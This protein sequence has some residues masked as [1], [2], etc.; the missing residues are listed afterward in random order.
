MM[1]SSD[2]AYVIVTFR[3]NALQV[4]GAQ[5]LLAALKILWNDYALRIML[6]RARNLTF[7]HL[8]VGGQTGVMNDSAAAASVIGGIDDGNTMG[9]TVGADRV[10]RVDGGM[11]ADICT[12]RETASS[13]VH[14]QTSPISAEYQAN[15]RG[16]L[17]N[18]PCP[19]YIHISQATSLDAYV[20]AF[21]AYESYDISFMIVTCLLNNVLFPLLAVMVVSADCLYRAIDQPSAVT[22]TYDY[23]SCNKLEL[24]L[25]AVQ[26]ILD[27][28]YVCTSFTTESSMDSYY[29]PFLYSYQC[30]S[31]FLR[32]YASL[33]GVMF[34]MVGFLLP[35]AKVL[36][37][38]F[39]A[40]CTPGSR[41][42][43]FVLRLVPLPLRP[44][45]PCL[46]P[47]MRLPVFFEKQRFV[48]RLMSLLSVLL[49]F[50]LLFPPLGLLQCAAL[51]C[52]IYYEQLVLGRL[53][54]QARDRGI[55]YVRCIVEH[56]CS[57]V[58]RPIVQ[59]VSAIGLFACAIFS[60]F[61]FDTLGD[62]V[63]W[64]DALWALFITLLVPPLLYE[65][66]VRT[67]DHWGG[68]SAA[69]DGFTLGSSLL[70]LL[71]PEIVA[72]FFPHLS[73]W[74]N[75]NLRRQ[76]DSNPREKSTR[77]TNAADNG[78]GTTAAGTGAVD[79]STQGAKESR[80]QQESQD[81]GDGAVSWRYYRDS[82]LAS[83]FFTLESASLRHSVVSMQ[84]VEVHARGGAGT[85]ARASDSP[86]LP[87]P[88][89]S[90][91]LMSTPR[92][93]ELEMFS[94]PS[95]RLNS[96]SDDKRIKY[97]LS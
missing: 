40:K 93:S 16:N 6:T 45:A 29:P 41:M 60:F 90:A 81:E 86:R 22:S 61:V 32:K 13:L 47:G 5:F 20:K 57:G 70:L 19:G 30:S 23:T 12:E 64:R 91:S 58:A 73:H 69:G 24:T 42:Y 31:V 9:G 25:G 3:G 78:G 96:T 95:A 53:L 7:K 83:G 74:A 27:T 33:Y 51:Y 97:P 35:S 38:L 21:E 82:S 49:T 76:A 28:D 56:E 63:G 68:N 11:H 88:A 34:V 89:T 59:S 92:G 54:C 79:Q 94:R 17:S 62:A 87:P 8:G 1:L 66:A 84:G 4:A 39:L 15:S 55:G 37:C 77:S 10:T 43:S 50:G 36:S 85:D 18:L 14:Q 72:R 71:E 26:T 48:V 2:V 44:L 65:A 46:Q 52:Y 80:S 67:A 75:L